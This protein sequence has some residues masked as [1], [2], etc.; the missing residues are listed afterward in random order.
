MRQLITLFLILL[1]SWALAQDD[2]ISAQDY[3]WDEEGVRIVVRGRDVYTVW[4]DGKPFARRSDVAGI[5]G[6]E[7]DDSEP[8]VELPP[9]LEEKHFRL[10]LSPGQVEIAA[11]VQ[12]HSHF[13]AKKA[14]RANA[15][16]LRNES[17]RKAALQKY[18]ATMPYLEGRTVKFV[19]DTGFVRAYVRVTNLGA[20]TSP[21]TTV[22]VA[23]TD[24]WGKAFAQDDGVVPALSPGESVTLEFFSMVRDEQMTANGVIRGQGNDQVRIYISQPWIP[25]ELR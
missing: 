9:L 23:F 20:G 18:L 1:T 6:L 15:R 3:A 24:Y 25:Q 10:K 22:Q 21:A 8:F 12:A 14:R 7:P 4:R 17:A 13:D 5:L 11:P 16:H 2:W 19:A